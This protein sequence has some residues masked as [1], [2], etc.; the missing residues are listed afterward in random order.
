MILGNIMGIL[1]VGVVIFLIIRKIF[2]SGS[3]CGNQSS[4][5]AVPKARVHGSR[6]ENA[7]NQKFIQSDE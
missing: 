6:V 5:R 3:C 1:G 2:K 7:D 4:R